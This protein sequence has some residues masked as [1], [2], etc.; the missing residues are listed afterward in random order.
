MKKKIYPCF[1]MGKQ[2]PFANCVVVG[3]T[4]YISGMNARSNE[5]GEAVSD[6]IEG[7]TWHALEQIDLAMKEAGSSLKN[8][9]KTTTF[10]KDM[11]ESNM[12]DKAFRF[13]RGWSHSSGYP[14]IHEVGNNGGW[15]YRF[16]YQEVRRGPE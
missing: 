1:V 6:T 14:G 16:Y 7:Q 5:T 3:K 13:P 8:L 2:K 15:S 10:L 11:K 12:L 4:I 9:V